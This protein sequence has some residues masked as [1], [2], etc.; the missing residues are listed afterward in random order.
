MRLREILREG[1]N[2]I[3]GATD[4]PQDKVADVV[5]AA[6][7]LLP[8]IARANLA[9]DIGSAGYKAVPAGDIDL[10]I[11]ADDLVKQFK[12]A[13]EKD[14]VKAAKQALEEYLQQKG[15]VANKSGRNVHV[16]I[17]FHGGIAQVDYMVIDDVPTVA[18]YHQHG[19]RGMYDDPEFKGSDIF[20]VMNS[21]G[22]ALGL[23]F[24][25]FSG[26]LMRRDDNT[27][28]AKDRDAVAKILL[29]PKATADDL[30]SVKSILK[31]LANDPD[32]DA[33]LAQARESAAKGIIN[34]PGDAT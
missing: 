31:A 22:K 29:N 34:L 9:T 16:G 24:D 32:R 4:V 13:G 30:N 21:I 33:K 23:K 5:A 28:V 20:I 8:P 12:T 18:P 26:K 10:M 2:Q 27:V 19:P 11:E 7:K 6:T 15:Y 1:G 25:A 3:P 14:P 17:P